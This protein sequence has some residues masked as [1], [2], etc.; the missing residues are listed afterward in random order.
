ME[1]RLYGD[2]AERLYG[3]T[4][5]RHVAALALNPGFAELPWVVGRGNPYG[6][7]ALRISGTDADS[8]ADAGQRDWQQRR[9]MRRIR[10]V[11]R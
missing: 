3:L 10:R 11:R 2:T 4:A 1:E 5:N 8:D 9:Y 6:R 7:L